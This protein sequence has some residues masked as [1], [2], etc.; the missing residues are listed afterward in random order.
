M[1]KM[2]HGG[3]REESDIFRGK[4]DLMV[5]CWAQWAWF[6]CIPLQMVACSQALLCTVPSEWGSALCPLPAAPEQ[7][8][9]APSLQPSCSKKKQYLK[10]SL[11]FFPPFEISC[12]F[13]TEHVFLCTVIGANRINSKKKGREMRLSEGVANC[14]RERP[15]TPGLVTRQHR[16]VCFRPVQTSVRLVTQDG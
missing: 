4:S 5:L 12:I 6:V 10:T 13:F 15:G 11:I 2:G 9:W 7:H 14:E 3:K 8:Y 16:L 1:Q